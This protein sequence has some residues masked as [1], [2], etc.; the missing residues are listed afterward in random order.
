MTSLSTT[1][2]GFDFAWKA[3]QQRWEAAKAVWNDSVQRKF[4]QEYW[5]PLDRQVHVTRQEMARLAEL[6]AKARLSVKE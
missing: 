2:E 1:I 5:E 4:E 3:L 6:I